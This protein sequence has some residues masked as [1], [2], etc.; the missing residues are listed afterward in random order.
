MFLYTNHLDRTVYGHIF[1]VSMNIFHPPDE[2]QIYTSIADVCS[3]CVRALHQMLLCT[4]SSF[5]YFSRIEVTHTHKNAYMHWST[6]IRT[7]TQTLVQKY[8][9]KFVVFFRLF[10]CNVERDSTTHIFLYYFNTHVQTVRAHIRE[11]R[12]QYTDT[13]SRVFPK[14]KKKCLEI[15]RKKSFFS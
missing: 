14:I 2:A 4:P 5:M 13:D 8:S 15:L 12:T 7:H 3:R 9:S 11:R 1:T 10:V 6:Y